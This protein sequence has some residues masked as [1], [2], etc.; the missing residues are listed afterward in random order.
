[1]LIWLFYIVEV[2][3]TYCDKVSPHSPRGLYLVEVVGSSIIDKNSI[4]N[5]RNIKGLSLRGYFN[6]MVMFGCL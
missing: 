5:I 2:A 1:M 4:S 6:T 3:K